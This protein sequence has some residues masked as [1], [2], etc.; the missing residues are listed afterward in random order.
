MLIGSDALNSASTLNFEF[1][2]ID[3]VAEIAQIRSI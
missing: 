3:A 1:K 2:T